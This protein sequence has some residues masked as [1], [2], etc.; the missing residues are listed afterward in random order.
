MMRVVA[1]VATTLLLRMLS[2]R[3][4]MVSPYGSGYCIANMIIM[5]RVNQTLTGITPTITDQKLSLRKMIAR[6]SHVV[7]ESTFVRTKF[8]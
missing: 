7:F 8:S 5:M 3:G 2:A 1:V 6:I 4:L